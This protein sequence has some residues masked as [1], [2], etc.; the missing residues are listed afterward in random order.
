MQCSRK[1]R[2]PRFARNDR[3]EFVR[4]TYCHSGGRRC[5]THPIL[6]LR[7]QALSPHP[8]LSFRGASVIAAPHTVIPAAGV[9][10]APRTVI[11]AASVIAA[12]RIVTPAAGVVAIPH[13]VIP[14]SA[15]TW[16]SLLDFIPYQKNRQSVKSFRNRKKGRRK[17][18]G[19]IWLKNNEKNR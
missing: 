17:Y 4:A 6:S 2:L 16:E 15:A 5:Y 8:I 13:T 10:A 14:R 11:P 1:K 3:A 12:P 9:I 19:D 7:R 18:S